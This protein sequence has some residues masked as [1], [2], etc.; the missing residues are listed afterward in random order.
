MTSE[1]IRGKN[2]VCIACLWMGVSLRLAAAQLEFAQPHV[3]IE[4]A[5]DK[6][7]ATATFPFTNISPTLVDIRDIQ[8]ECDCVQAE[9][10]PT[11]V[12]SRQSGRVSVNFRARVRNGTELVRAKVIT[13]AGEIY[14]ISVTANVHSYV[15]IAPLT[16]HWRKGELREGREFVV[17]STGLGKLRFTHVAAVRDAKVE[18]FP[19]E[20]SS[21]IRVLV[22]P[23][24]GD[25]RF[26]SV[27][28]VTATLEETGE[29]KVYDLHVRGD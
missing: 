6:Q 23:P 9:A 27:V 8:T 21:S 10:M 18:M 20:D 5:T 15:D 11:S 22:T 2:T 14:P 19:G 1:M 17:S 29:T 24:S 3:T 7:A 16:L 4:L 26:Q 25:K 13:D 28:L 12:G